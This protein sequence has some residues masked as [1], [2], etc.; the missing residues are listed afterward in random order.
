VGLPYVSYYAA[1]KHAL[2][3]YFKSLRFELN[4]FNIKVVMVEPMSFKTSIGES[5][6]VATGNIKDYDLF[7][8]KVTAYTKSTF[9]KAP[10]PTPVIDTVLQTVREPN[11]KF[12]YPV[13]KGSSIILLLQK[14]AYNV[15]E[16]SILKSV[17]TSK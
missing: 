5:G 9:D 2:E 14:F 1:S 7:R 11:P 13:G 3:G 15:F 4:Q 10:E 8:Q 12:S 16:K 17:N 6:T